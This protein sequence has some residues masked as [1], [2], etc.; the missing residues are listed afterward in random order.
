VVRWS[1]VVCSTPGSS[2]PFSRTLLPPNLPGARF[3]FGGGTKQNMVRFKLPCKKGATFHVSSSKGP[4]T[5][6][7]TILHGSSCSPSGQPGYT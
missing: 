1:S 7:V 2:V 5:A 6:S 3:Y 4:H